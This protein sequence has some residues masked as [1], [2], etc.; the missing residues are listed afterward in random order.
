MEANLH[1]FPVTHHELL[2]RFKCHL[3]QTFIV[4]IIYIQTTQNS[5]GVNATT[6]LNLNAKHISLA[7]KTTQKPTL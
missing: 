4:P 3:K 7:E 2:S 6:T 1:T 5:T